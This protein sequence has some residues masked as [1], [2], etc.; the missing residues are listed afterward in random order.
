[1]I[2]R[3]ARETLRFAAAAFVADWAFY[4]VFTS[5]PLRAIELG[6]G[7]LT[8]GFLP[9]LSSI[10]YIIAS[11]TFG[12][13]SDR[14]GR[15]RMARVGTISMALGALLLR[16]APNLSSLFLFLPLVSIGGGL[17][18]PAIQAELG[19]RGPGGGLVRR[20]GFFNVAWSSGKMLGFWTAGHLAQAYG[21]SNPLLFAVAFELAVFV[22]T[23]PDRP[24]AA[25]SDATPP[26]QAP[27]ESVRARYRLVSRLANLAAFGVG[28]TLNYQFPKRLFGIGLHAGDLGNFL[29]LVGLWQTLAFALLAWRRGWEWRP[30]VLVATMAAGVI[31]VG[32]LAWA[33]H[34]ALILACAPGIGIATGVAYSASLYHSL[35][36]SEGRGKNTGIHEAL[37]GSGSLFLPLLGGALARSAGLGAPYLLCA[38][39][40]GVVA[41][42]AIALLR[43]WRPAGAR[44]GSAGRPA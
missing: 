28:A 22:L 43:A 14:G 30:A 31:S 21:A 4:L 7:P 25:G 8:L 29:G 24:P 3:P 42:L 5:V 38:A 23:P 37:L 15:M 36:S 32:A 1:M 27:G 35:H 20:M 44:I 34:E 16:S 18:W 19:D 17:F 40:F 26:E 10:V 33:R 12:R 13:M 39:A 2:D 11:L 6:A 9:A 41:I